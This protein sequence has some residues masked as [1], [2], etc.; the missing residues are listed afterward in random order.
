MAIANTKRI[1]RFMILNS[2]YEKESNMLVKMTVT[3]MGVI[4]NVISNF[5][6]HDIHQFTNAFNKNEWMV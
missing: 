3:L 1:E 2:V 5:I 6:E 4:F